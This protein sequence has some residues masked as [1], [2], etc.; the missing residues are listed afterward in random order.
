MSRQKDK[1]LKRPVKAAD[2]YKQDLTKQL[3][4]KAIDFIAEYTAHLAKEEEQEH[5]SL[6]IAEA[7]H[8]PHETVVYDS[9]KRLVTGVVM[10]PEVFD[11]HGDIID[12][13]TIEKACYD[14]MESYQQV[15][16]QHQFEGPA[17]IV[18]SWLT[19]EDGLLGKQKVRK[20]SWLMTVRIDDSPE[21]N[22]IWKLIR[23]GK[24]TGFSFGGEGDVYNYE[25]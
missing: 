21:G 14:F 5:L 25:R 9:D 20:G 15:G 7:G 11:T 22:K 4:C 18:E 10:E 24:I 13:Q 6:D 19:K 1:K 12:A 3:L 8:N 17:K 23:E 16:V 2:C